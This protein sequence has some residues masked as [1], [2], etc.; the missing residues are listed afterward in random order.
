MGLIEN[1]SIMVVKMT[2]KHIDGR[3]QKV[4]CSMH[5][6]IYDIVSVKSAVCLSSACITLE[7]APPASHIEF[8]PVTTLKLEVNLQYVIESY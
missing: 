3:C 5:K 6:P 4:T 7:S 2:F 8:I 1:I